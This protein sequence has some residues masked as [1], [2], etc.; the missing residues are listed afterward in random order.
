MA[1][2]SA[3]NKENAWNHQ[4]SERLRDSCPSE[5]PIHQS[6]SFKIILDFF[7]IRNKYNIPKREYRPEHV[8]LVSPLT[9]QFTGATYDVYPKVEKSCTHMFSTILDEYFGSCFDQPSCVN[10]RIGVVCLSFETS[11]LV[12]MCSIY[13][14]ALLAL[15]LAMENWTAQQAQI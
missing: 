6:V 2:G 14:H 5:N 13:I 3:I 12:E 8:P 1:R 9:T 15:R 11:P 10:I 4:S 7:N